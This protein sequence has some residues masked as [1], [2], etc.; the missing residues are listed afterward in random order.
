MMRIHSAE[1]TGPD[2]KAVQLSGLW[3]SEGFTMFYADLLLRRAGLPAPEST[4]TAHLEH[5][6]GGYL[7]NPDNARSSAEQA[8][9]VAF[10]SDSESHPNVWVQGE[11]LGA[12]LD[13][14]IRGATDGKR[15]LDD[16]MRAMFANFSGERGF[17]TN[18]VERLA[19]EVCAC[20]L[21]PFFD[22]YIRGASGIDFNNYLQLAGLKTEVQWKRAARPDGTL[23]PDLRVGAYSKGGLLFLSLYP[24]GAWMRAG[25]RNGDQLVKLPRVA[26]ECVTVVGGV[27]LIIGCGRRPSWSGCPEPSAVNVQP[28]VAR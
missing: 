9:R 2:Y 22:A 12:M 23:I 13:L 17:T 27:L 5:L 20:G 15:S 7:V 25:L 18:D 21:K 28:T 4:R 26:V 1:Y 16:L 3:F 11:L 6:I 10:S 19:E 14:T 24:G 8:S